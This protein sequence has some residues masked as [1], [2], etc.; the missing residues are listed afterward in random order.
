MYNNGNQILQQPGM[1]IIRNEM[2]HETRV[3]LLSDGR[4]HLDPSI[5]EYMGDPRGHW[6]GNTLVIEIDELHGSGCDR[7]GMARVDPGDPG[8]HS[9]DFEGN[10]AADPGWM[11]TR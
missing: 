1:V 10:R 4:P 6:E 5:R 7:L 11:R 9:K 2:I 8:H 3:I